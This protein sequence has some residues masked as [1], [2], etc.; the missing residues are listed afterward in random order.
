MIR[1]SDGELVCE[2]DDCGQEEYGG[3]LEFS[4][5]I[6]DL[7]EKGW[8]ARKVEDEWQHDCPTCQGQ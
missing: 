6:E 1:K 5:F 2:C 8:R 7:R 3:T 4:A